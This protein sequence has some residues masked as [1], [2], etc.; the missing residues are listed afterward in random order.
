M[1]ASPAANNAEGSSSR[2]LVTRLRVALVPALIDGSWS[3]I[4]ENH[5]KVGLKWRSDF[6]S[7]W[8]KPKYVERVLEELGEDEVVALARRVLE[9][10]PE[11]RDFALEDS[12][13]WFDAGGVSQVSEVTR[14]NLAHA[15]ERR[16]L[17]PSETPDD[18]LGRFARS[19]GAQRFEH[20]EDGSVCTVSVDLLSLFDPRL[21]TRRT[22]TLSSHLAL[23]DAYGFRE[24][25][26]ARLFQLLEFLAHPTVLRGDAQTAL[27]SA[28]N[29]V[30]AADRFHLSEDEQLSGHP[31]FKVRPSRGGVAGRPK[32]LIFASTGPKPELGFV[33]AV[34][35]DI[36]ILR[37]GEH[38]L[39]YDEPIGHAGL[40]WFKLA[41][42]WA[43]RD[44]LEPGS[45]EAR[46]G[47]GDRLARSLASEP[48]R[49]L[50]SAY[51]K[52]FRS[53]LGDALPALVPQVYLHY[54]PVTLRALEARGEQR[55]FDVQ[56]MDFLML[57]PHGVR[58][59]IEVDGQ[60]HYATGIDA[61]ARP[62]PEEYAR[63][64]RGDRELR[65]NGYEVY[66]FG[67]HELHHAA[68]H[69]KVVEDFFVRLFRRH[70]V[71]E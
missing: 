60:Q 27:V 52:A 40:L 70:K 17:H 7:G 34:N 62:S 35:N 31:V 3:Q 39:V 65:L 57:L 19:N 22:A 21:P 12:L 42:W 15:L 55:R 10:F 23:L 30:L 29:G 33:D 41:D 48:E 50:Y 6:A 24:W 56:R 45:L 58:I 36:A 26:D 13:L 63:T 53:R 61:S 9:Q 37:H 5:R 69:A 51:F 44:G 67:G 8:G 38:C 28:I 2:R 4:E 68:A 64:A 1:S 43:A 14:L 25:P 32:N 59:V 16:R 47:L 11:R 54:D 20:A 49:R 46:K 71:I 18:V 66:R